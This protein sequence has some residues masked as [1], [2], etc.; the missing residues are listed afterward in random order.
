MEAALFETLGS[1]GFLILQ[2]MLAEQGYVSK[3]SV[4]S[5]TVN[6][7]H[8]VR[9]AGAIWEGFGSSTSIADTWLRHESARV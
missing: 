9:Y 6:R 7:T 1:L 3:D 5:F 4:N 8:L 2:C